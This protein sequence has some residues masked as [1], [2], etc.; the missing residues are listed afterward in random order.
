M[1]LILVLFTS[2]I[3]DKFVVLAK[4]HIYVVEQAFDSFLI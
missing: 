1:M 4:K 3:F 2:L